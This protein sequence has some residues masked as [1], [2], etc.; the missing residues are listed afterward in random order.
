MASM[1]VVASAAIDHPYL[2]AIMVNA[3]NDTQTSLAIA[4]YPHWKEN[5]AIKVSFTF[6]IYSLIISASLIIGMSF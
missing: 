5:I 3:S 6:T 4:P 1:P 2:L